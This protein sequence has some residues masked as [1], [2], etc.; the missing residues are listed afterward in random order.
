MSE[1]YKQTFHYSWTTLQV[2]SVLALVVT[3]IQTL[4]RTLVQTVL[5]LVQT[6]VQT[7]VK[8]LVQTLVP[9]R[10]RHGGYTRVLKT[11]RRI[12][13]AAPMAYIE[14]IDR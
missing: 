7:L 12:S 1:H 11:R 14:F 9:F 4:V 6:L 3:L 10:D 5:T 8:T 13:D 2:C